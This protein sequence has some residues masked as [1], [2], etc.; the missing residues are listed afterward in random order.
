MIVDYFG[1]QSELRQTKWRAQRMVLAKEG[2][3]KSLHGSNEW[4][5]NEEMK[6]RVLDYLL[7]STLARL[8]NFGLSKV[9]R[10][11]AEEGEEDLADVQHGQSLPSACSPRLFHSH[12]RFW[13]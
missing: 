12:F 8:T 13:Y 1:H 6:V 9:P 11:T 3:E 4:G 2:R 10:A 5:L 7:A